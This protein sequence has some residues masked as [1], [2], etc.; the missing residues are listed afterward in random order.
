M[1][2]IHLINRLPFRMGKWNQE[3]LV[4]KMTL[5][6]Y[7]HR[8][9]KKTEKDHLRLGQRFWNDYINTDKE[10]D[11]FNLFH[12]TDNSLAIWLIEKWLQDHHYF[13]TLPEKIR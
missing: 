4:D 1:G 3:I 12:T 11:D 7:I 9:F 10:L 13:N 5:S 2:D 8:H 6:D